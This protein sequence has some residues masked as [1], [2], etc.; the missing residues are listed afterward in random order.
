MAGRV[1]MV[2]MVGMAES[3]EGNAIYLVGLLLDRTATMYINPP[4]LETE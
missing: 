4:S 2:G 3:D 1:M